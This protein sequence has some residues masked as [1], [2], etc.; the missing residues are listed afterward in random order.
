MNKA[1]TKSH[2][3]IG[4]CHDSQSWPFTECYVGLLVHREIPW[5]PRPTICSTFKQTCLSID[6]S[7]WSKQTWSFAAR[8]SKPAPPSASPSSSNKPE[9]AYQH[10]I[11][12]NPYNCESSITTGVYVTLTPPFTHKE[13]FWNWPRS[14]NIYMG[15]LRC[16]PK[17]WEHHET[18]K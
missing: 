1:Q 5:F 11:P 3:S 2:G 6:Q 16:L 7:K 10:P 18:L 12:I 9:V 15:T 14:T 8:P 13:H 17:V 4:R